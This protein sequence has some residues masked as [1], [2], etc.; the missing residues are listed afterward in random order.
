MSAYRHFRLSLQAEFRRKVHR[1]VR[2]L[3]ADLEE[4]KKAVD[5]SDR[6]VVLGQVHQRI[7]AL[8]Q[9]AYA[10]DA[11][12]VRVVSKPSARKLGTLRNCV[13]GYSQRRS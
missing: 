8:E 1:E 3:W 7:Y 11:P 12:E 6:A 10:V 2:A 13:P 9:A 4:L 5:E